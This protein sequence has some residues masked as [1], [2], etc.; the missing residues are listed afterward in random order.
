MNPLALQICQEIQREGPMRFARFMELAL[1]APGLGYYERQKEIGRGGDFFTSVSVGEVFGQ[2]LAL[3]FSEW[4]TDKT[5]PVQIVECGAHQGQL[6]RDILSWMRERQPELFSRLEYW[7]IEPSADRRQWQKQTLRDF[8]HRVYFTQS[9]VGL[10]QE[11]GGIDGVIFSNELLDAM[12]VRRLRWNVSWRNWQEWCVDCEGEKFIWVV[13]ELEKDLA[14]P[15]VPAELAAVLPD[16]FTVEISPAA[17]QWYQEAANVLRSGRLVTIDYGLEEEE[18]F[19]P[20]RSKGTLRVYSKHHVGDDILSTVGEQDITAHVNF[21]AVQR[22]GE[23]AGLK[24]ELFVP[25]GRFL[26]RIFEK[27]VNHP[28]CFIPWTPARIR[29][30]QT[31]THPEHLGRA[32]RVIVQGR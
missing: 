28:A 16:G 23:S 8:G 11:R 5:G 20:G 25:Q 4:T 9:L 10:T 30:F 27:T 32:F 12:P 21:T 13:A 1:Y 19:A 22:T 3:Q 15:E 18:F 29:Q 6:A 7:I 24:T 17:L 2:L 31:L 26:T 14:F